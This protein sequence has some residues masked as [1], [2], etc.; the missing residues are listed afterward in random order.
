MHLDRRADQQH[1]LAF[2]GVLFEPRDETVGEPPAQFLVQLGKLSRYGDLALGQDLAD[3]DQRFDKARRGLVED[4][5]RIDVRY[6]RQ[7]IAPG[8]VLTG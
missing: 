8:L 7:C 4:D 1:D 6:L 2:G 3:G 5:R